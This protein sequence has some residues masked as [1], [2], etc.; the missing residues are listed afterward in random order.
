[1]KKTYIYSLVCPLDGKVKYIGK[2]NNPYLRFKKHKSL[3]DKNTGDNILKNEWIR[4]LLSVGETPILNILEEVDITEWKIKEKFYI[5]K[6]KD[7]GEIF[8]ICGGGNGPTFGNSGSFGQGLNDR[9]VRVV[10]LTK[11]GEYVRTFD[12]VTEGRNFI[13]GK[14]IHNVLIGKRKTSGGYIWIY[15]DKYNK[16]TEQELKK[17]VS[18]A[19]YINKE[20]MGVGGRF[21]KGSSTWNKGRKGDISKKRKEIHQYSLEGE[22][23]RSWEY[24]KD[25]A[26]ELGCSPGNITL[27]AIGKSNSAVG[28]KWSYDKI[29]NDF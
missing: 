22:Y 18:N 24:S 6:Y 2:S 25:A 29:N 7:L 14:R 27:C 17:I 20:N 28:Y 5:K 9:K 1:M 12:S 23:I 15:E 19:N 11:E 21:S 13:G 8:N 16:M 4:S 10:C 26:D 3:S